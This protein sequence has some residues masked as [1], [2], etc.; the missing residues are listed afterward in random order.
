MRLTRSGVVAAVR[1]GAPKP[2]FSDEPAVRRAVLAARTLSYSTGPSGQHLETLFERWGIREQLRSRIV[3]APPGTP[4][5]ALVADGRAELG[6]QQLSE[7][8]G[9]A[10]I[11][12]VGPLPPALQIVTIFSGGIAAGG[13]QPAAAQAVLR[14]CAS[15]ETHATKQ[16][17]GMDAG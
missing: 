17:Y 2:E 5:A 7:M 4:V 16:Q 3:V 6:F 8:Q 1:A 12:I 10:G 15:L 11:E 9:R 14:Y 13:S